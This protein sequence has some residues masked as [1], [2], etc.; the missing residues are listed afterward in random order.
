MYKEYDQAR[1]DCNNGII[2]MK[3]LADIHRKLWKP[4]SS[5]N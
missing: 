1:I 4:Y 2:T 5:K 3:E